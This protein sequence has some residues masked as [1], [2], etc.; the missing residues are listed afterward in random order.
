[1]LVAGTVA[2]D[3]RRA[4]KAIASYADYDFAGTEV[5]VSGSSFEDITVGAMPEEVAEEEV[6][7]EVVEE[8]AEEEAEAEEVVEE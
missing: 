7:E 6:A 2:D 3:T 5:M 8:V 1:M 4:A